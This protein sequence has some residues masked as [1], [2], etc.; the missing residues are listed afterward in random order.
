M[1]GKMLDRRDTSMDLIRIVA[2]FFVMSVH[3][4]YHT[5]KTVENNAH[6]GFYNLTVNGYGPIEGIVK[7]I[8][9]GNFSDLHGPLIF[10]MVLMKVLFSACVPLFMILT[11]YLM[12]TKTLSRKYYYGI[13]KTL[14]V[15][16]LASVVC[17]FFKS[18]YLNPQAKAAFEQ[19]DLNTMFNA[20][21]ATE[22][23]EP[24]DYIL[25]IF[26]FSGANYSWYV[27]MYIGLFLI[28]PFLNLA[29]NKL[30]SQRKKLVL[31]GTVVFL[32]ILP[33][34]VNAFRF[35]NANWWLNPMSDNK[36]YQKLIPA[37]WMG[38]MYPVAYYF[39]GAYIREYG[40]KLKTRAMLPLFGIML[41]LCTAFSFYRSYGGN[42]QAG[43]WIYWYGVE[44]YIISSLLFVLLS[45]VR[46]NNWH[47]TVRKVMWKVSDVTFGM[48][49]LSFIFD[50]L[51]YNSWLNEIRRTG[52]EKLPFY[53]VAVPLCFLFSLAASLAVTT[54]AKGLIILYEKIKKWFKEQLAEPRKVN[55][56]DVLFAALLI[57][58]L[59]CAFWKVRYGFGG[60]DEAF[61]LTIPHR[62]AKGD[63]LFRDEW[64]LS[65]MCSIL[66][67]PF[68]W[69][70]TTVT[71]S[72]D[73]I[74]LAARI[75]YVFV[76]GA[77]AVLI[78]SR[79]RKYGYL[80]VFACVLYFLFTPYDIMALGYDSMGVE[81]VLLAG[82][83]LATADY[84]KKLWLI[85]SGLC[86]AGAVLCCPFL[87]L[88]Y[89]LFALCMGVHA[90]LKGKRCPLMLQSKLFAPRTFLFFT[91]GV[92]ILAVIFLLFTLPRVGFSGLAENLSY[93]LQDPEHPPVE[94]WNKVGGYFRSV[95]YMQPHFKYAVY[96]YCLMAL[97]MLI[98]RKRRQHRSVYLTVTV[99]IVLYTHM[100]L[101]PS[102]HDRTYNALMFPPVFA[103]ITAYVL[104][105]N[106]QRELFAG[107]FIP[108][109]IYSFT[110][111][112][113]SNQGFYVISMAFAA[114]NV[115]SFVF[116][117]QLIREMRETPDNITYPEAM[118]RV[119]LVMVTVMFIMQGAF[120]IGA[121]QRHCFWDA[122]PKNLTTD[123]EE[124]PA[125]G[126]ITSAENARVYNEIYA[127]LSYYW[128]K[129][130]GNL[131][132]LT[133]RSW[134]YLA[135]DMPYG[136]FSAWLSGENPNSIKRLQNYWNLN[137]DKVPR[138]IYVPMNSKW[139]MNELLSQLG[140]MGYDH[141]RLHAGY[142]L[143]SNAP[144]IPSVNN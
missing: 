25:S 73:G 118:K 37:F 6:M 106:K 137:P 28:A 107:L 83:L 125:A 101:L 64:N 50:M 138:Y 68:V 46:A 11:G 135:A 80:S 47:P 109:I 31:V 124:G 95:F 105:E 63:A 103:G 121:K 29:Y 35:D 71:G 112:Y 8:E 38:S 82:V 79:L 45:R 84:D 20:I 86:F 77:A 131:L 44:P 111:H 139:N 43:S 94:L 52:F 92:G 127:D 75:F 132:I 128:D 87:V 69:V 126:L 117:G 114:V 108:G 18:V 144:R 100:L 91:C 51:I 55:W 70:Y 60:N 10:L 49:L 57:G 85:L 34:L 123:I 88:V 72:T 4:L 104:C 62:L 22:S 90:L 5:S 93:M 2:V 26:G 99:C 102:L 116:L 33:S 40:I 130:E 140:S 32:A 78:Y 120:E 119:A 54:L 3:F 30:D 133:E 115:A 96:S 74:I 27:E 122:D 134:T 16:V 97:I 61:Y 12:S 67:L 9:S 42:F 39:T 76:H 1:K 41:F 59:L 98:D 143:E 23:Y 129:D 113:T 65:Q 110:V 89:V 15:F 19:F 7:F 136:T 36:G 53:F 58:A 141:K 21:E 17:M 13:R 81:L 66:Q 24:K 56:Q 142:V 14:V 48:Y